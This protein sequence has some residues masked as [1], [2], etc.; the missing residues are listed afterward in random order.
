MRDTAFLSQKSLPAGKD[1]VQTACDLLD[2]LDAHSGECV[3]MAANMIGELKRIIVFTDAQLGENR[4]MFNPV[5]KSASG[6]YEIEEGCLSLEGVRSTVRYRK[7]TVEYLDL[8]F[9]KR[10][11]DFTGFTAQIIQHEIDMTNGILI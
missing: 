2:T 7:I 9:R 8:K 6:K 4:V 3:G 5:I 11:G 10:K 1:D